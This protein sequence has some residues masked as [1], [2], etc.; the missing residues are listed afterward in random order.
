MFDLLCLRLEEQHV[1]MAA[2]HSTLW[3]KVL[4]RAQISNRSIRHLQIAS[5]QGGFFFFF[6]A[7]MQQSSSDPSCL[8]DGGQ[9]TKQM[10]GGCRRSL[11]RLLGWPVKERL[12]SLYKSRQ[13]SRST[14][15]LKL[16]FNKQTIP[17]RQHWSLQDWYSFTLLGFATKDKQQLPRPAAVQQR[18]THGI[19]GGQH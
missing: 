8:R 14:T 3:G 18:A 9:R 1:L 5:P 6:P 13:S 19:A 4:F 10:D 11:T 15:S 16:Q 17:N 7:W 12:L 2:W